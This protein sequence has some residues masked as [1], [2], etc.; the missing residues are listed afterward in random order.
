MGLK[1][2][3]EWDENCFFFL[4]NV[5]KFISDVYYYADAVRLSLKQECAMISDDPF[6]NGFIIAVGLILGGLFLYL[7]VASPKIESDDDDVAS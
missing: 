7:I 4:N 2:H 1:S 6:F 5:F 3:P